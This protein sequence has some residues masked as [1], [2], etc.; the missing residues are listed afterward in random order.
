MNTINQELI[1]F[2]P[3]PNALRGRTIAITGASDGIGRA[4]AIACAK[5]GADIILL[6]RSEKKLEAVYDELVELGSQR[7]TI[8]PLDFTKA[9]ERNYKE[10]ADYIRQDSGALSALIHCA[11]TL[12]K[13]EPL[14]QVDESLFEEILQTNL[15]SNF[16]LTKACIPLLS[17][18]GHGSI[19]FTSSSVGR[20]GR[21][22]WGGYSI[23]KFGVEAMSQIWAAELYNTHSIRVNSI[24]PGAT[25]TAMRRQ[26]YPGETP[27]DNLPPEKIA[28][29][30]L[31]L[32][33]DESSQVNGQQLDAQPK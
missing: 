3:Q 19:V 9:R 1:K 4:I 25:N 28:E 8:V 2:K 33:C 20:Q 23:S 17:A 16:L 13:L 15:T 32:L 27:S 22:F 14:Q 18:S 24:N 30:Y 11:G 6:G 10:I 12:G 31:Y 21:A 7:S 26:A 5:I 29:R